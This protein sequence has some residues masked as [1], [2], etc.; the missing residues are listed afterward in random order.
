MLLEK[1][2][3]ILLNVRLPVYNM[4]TETQQVNEYVISTMLFFFVEYFFM[5]ERCHT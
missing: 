4:S 5:V 1:K 2:K 3:L